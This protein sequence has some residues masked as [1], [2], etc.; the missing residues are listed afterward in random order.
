MSCT[1]ILVEREEV[2]P[3][4][5]ICHPVSLLYSAEEENICYCIWMILNGPIPT[6][7]AQV[8]QKH[9]TSITKILHPAWLSG[10]VRET[11]TVAKDVHREYAI[12][13]Q[14]L[15]MVTRRQKTDSRMTR[16]ILWR[17]Y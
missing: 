11:L 5:I 13:S 3:V 12:Q 16:F 2:P 1:V 17:L 14:A 7:V 4:A 10:Y 15:K 8:R 6:Q 9:F